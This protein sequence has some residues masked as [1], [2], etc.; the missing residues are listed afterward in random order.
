MSLVRLTIHTLKHIP[1]RLFSEVR[2]QLLISAYLANH[3]SVPIKLELF[4]LE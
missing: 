1:A 4:C 2:I 3:S